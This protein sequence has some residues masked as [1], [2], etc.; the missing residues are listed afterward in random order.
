VN[1]EVLRAVGYRFRATFAQRRGGYIAIVVLLALVGGVALGALAG[2]RRT[3]TSYPTYLA[4]LTEANWPV[5]HTGSTLK[6][7]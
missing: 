4:K 7:N 6:P 2:A 3:Q 1:R 5:G